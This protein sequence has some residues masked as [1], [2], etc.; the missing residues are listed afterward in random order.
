MARERGSGK[1][2]ERVVELLKE[3]VATKSM[4][5]VSKATGL[6]LAAIGRYLKGVG[7]PTTATLQKLA[8]YFGAR[9]RYLRGDPIEPLDRLL[10]GLRLAGVHA[11]DYNKKIFEL[12]AAADG[13]GAEEGGP[14][15]GDYWSLLLGSRGD[16]QRGAIQHLCE[17]FGVDP[18]WVETGRRPSLLT[19]S[20]I[21]GTVTERT[22][23]A[24]AFIPGWEGKDF[25]SQPTHGQ[26]AICA[27]CGGELKAEDLPEGGDP[28]GPLSFWPCETCCKS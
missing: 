5:E 6:G 26:A 11:E 13:E 1:T 17:A 22:V 25:K 7:E 23:K 27:R 9:V 18:Y 21:V 8:D 10:E 20:G 14:E 24:S 28:D 3:A 2:P 12:D 19:T 15:E 16:M 4:L